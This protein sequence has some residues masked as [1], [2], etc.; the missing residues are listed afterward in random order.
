MRRRIGGAET[1]AL[2]LRGSPHPL[3]PSP[4]ST[5]RAGRGGRGERLCD[6]GKDSAHSFLSF[7]LSRRG[8]S[9]SRGYP[10]IVLG[11]SG[12]VAGELLRLLAM[13]PSLRPAAVV[14]ESQAG[15]P[16]EAVFPHLA[17]CFPGTDLRAAGGPPGAL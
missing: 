15:E 4:G 12:Y 11:G 13:H 5:R 16:V 1:A 6:G 8:R 2:G 9:R 7:P 14:S 17:G 10:A 3:A